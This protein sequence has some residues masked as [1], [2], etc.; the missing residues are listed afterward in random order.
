M[1]KNRG[2]RVAKCPIGQEGLDFHQYCHEIYHWN[3]PSNPVDLE[4]R[5]GRIHRYKGHVIRKNLARDYPVSTLVNRIT[6]NTD[7]WEAVFNQALKD[8]KEDQTD[9][10]PFWIYE[11]DEGYK[12]YRYIPLV[13]L[14]RDNERLQYLTRTVAAYRVVLGQPRQ[15]PIKCQKITPTLELKNTSHTTKLCMK[16]YSLLYAHRSFMLSVLL[17]TSRTKHSAPVVMGK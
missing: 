3:L 15:K 2:V 11:S 6:K 10:V 17:T 16:G 1:A 4:Q 13:L 14:S 8:H 7:P 12:V 5:E 9:L